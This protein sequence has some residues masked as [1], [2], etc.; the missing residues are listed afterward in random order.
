MHSAHEACECR[1]RSSQAY[2]SFRL[3][4]VA[5]DLNVASSRLHGVAPCVCRAD[6][7]T[8]ASTAIVQLPRSLQKVLPE[9]VRERLE[10]EQ[11]GEDDKVGV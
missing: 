5:A 3:I 1:R 2:F 8:N 6:Q 4:S 11:E 9:S 7:A 10:E